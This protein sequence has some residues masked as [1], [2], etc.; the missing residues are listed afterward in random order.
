MT[1]PILR[2]QPRS[3]LE[4][5]FDLSRGDILV[6]TYTDLLDEDRQIACDIAIRYLN[7]FKRRFAVVMDM[8]MLSTLPAKQRAMYGAARDA[9]RDNY[10]R[11]HALTVYV[12]GDRAQR[13]MLTAI[14]WIS[15]AESSSGSVFAESLSD[16]LHLCR[17][18]LN[19]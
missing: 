10:K 11:H 7:A 9:V 3:I 19:P 14:G 12:V 4:S 18:A 8:R 5:Q 16:A 13:G 2:R 15:K 1:E 17:V 6:I